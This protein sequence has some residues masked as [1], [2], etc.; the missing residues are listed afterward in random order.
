MKFNSLDEYDLY[1]QEMSDLHDDELAMK[2][3][4]QE[5]FEEMMA[6][7]N[8]EKSSLDI[9]SDDFEINEIKIEKVKQPSHYQFI[10]MTVNDLIE[11]SSTHQEYM[12]W[13]RGNVIKYRMRAG[14]KGSI[15]ED[16]QKANEYENFYKEYVESNT[17]K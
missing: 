9:L 13:L 15:K 8:K 3:E 14:K 7:I 6:E 5:Q 11:K 10:D 16:I 4:R 2:A 12:G 1:I 17:P